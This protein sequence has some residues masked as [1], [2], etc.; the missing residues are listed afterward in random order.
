MMNML[1]I[2][3][4]LAVHSFGY[5]LI[6]GPKILLKIFFYIKLKRIYFKYRPDFI[7]HYVAKPNIYGSLAASSL[8]IPSVAV[9]TGLGYAFA[10]KSWLNIL[11]KYLYKRALKK[12]TGAWFLNNEDANMFIAKKIVPI[13]KVRVLP[14]EGVN[15]VHFF[16]TPI[17]M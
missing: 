12:I 4:K 14:G 7:F 1:F 9:I 8:K 11:V 5:P 13:E 10:K 15:T 6:T 17:T 2:S 16:L 3:G